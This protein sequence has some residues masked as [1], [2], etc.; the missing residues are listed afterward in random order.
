MLARLVGMPAANPNAPYLGLWSRVQG[1]E[2]EQLVHCLQQRR[3]VRAPLFRSTSHTV[4]AEDWLAFRPVLQPVLERAL[5]VASRYG[6]Q[7]DE[8]DVDRLL[9]RAHD[10][11]A[12][13]T[14]ST[15]ELGA[16]LA[17]H[18]PEHHPD[19]LARATTLLLP[20]L[21]VPHDG[22]GGADERFAIADDWL[23]RSPHAA[24]PAEDSRL[25]EMIVRYLGAFGPATLQ[26]IQAWSGLTDLG[27]EMRGLGGAVRLDRGEDGAELYDVDGAP[28]PSEETPVPVRF[29]PEHDNVLGAHHDR[30]R[31]VAEADVGT[32]HRRGGGACRTVLI[33]GYVRA[34]WAITRERGAAVLVVEPF[35]PLRRGDQRD[36]EDEGIRLLAF[37]ALGAEDYDVRVIEPN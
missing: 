14:K 11:L 2:A 32:L 33:G 19:A 18:W 17:E 31:V 3:A 34:T 12:A 36:L 6:R 20:V 24:S 29:L 21:Q 22:R 37:A 25:D 27:D 15:Q 13:G 30:A 9:A 16:E 10:L 4:L 23:G 8:L 5:W 35:G 1:F 26:D 28:R 7:L